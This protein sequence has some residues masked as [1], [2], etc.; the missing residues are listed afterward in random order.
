MKL[1]ITKTATI[2]QIPTVAA[3]LNDSNYR[4][5]YDLS[6]KLTSTTNECGQGIFDDRDGDCTFHRASGATVTIDLP[7]FTTANKTAQEILEDTVH[8][9]DLVLAAFAA[10]YPV[11]NEAATITLD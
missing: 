11:V 1:T 6:R 8:R 3:I 5:D 9:R 10:K 7:G 2:G 4:I